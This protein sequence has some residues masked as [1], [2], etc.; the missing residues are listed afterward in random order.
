MQTE[1][2]TDVEVVRIPYDRIPR[3]P[4]LS[5]CSFCVFANDL[6]EAQCPA[7]LSLDEKNPSNGL[8]QNVVFVKPTDYLLTRLTGEYTIYRTIEF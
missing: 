3:H 7:H 6:A 5:V 2:I 4:D 8:C 1:I